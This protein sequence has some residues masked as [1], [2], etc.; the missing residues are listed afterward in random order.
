[1]YEEFLGK[2]VLVIEPSGEQTVGVLKDIL[3]SKDKDVLAVLLET[4]KNKT[5]IP[6]PFK[7][8]REEVKEGEP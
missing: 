8:K 2:Q 4:K 6:F 1:M 3:Y 7:L 5:V